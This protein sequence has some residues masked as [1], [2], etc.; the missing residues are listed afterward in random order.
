MSRSN[1][2]K[3]P[4]SVWATQR[5]SSLASSV[6]AAAVACWPSA[7]GLDTRGEFGLG[8]KRSQMAVGAGV[9]GFLH[10]RIAYLRAAVAA[11]SGSGVGVRGYRERV[12]SAGGD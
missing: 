8:K 10:I 2:L 3:S 7:I 1:A 5:A 4:A 11:N 9:T 12:A 6:G